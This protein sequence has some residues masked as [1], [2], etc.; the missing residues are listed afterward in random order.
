[1][2]SNPETDPVEYCDE[3]NGCQEVK[4]EFVIPRGDSSKAL[5]ALEEVL[6]PMPE[7][8][9]TTVEGNPPES[10]LPGRNL[11][12]SSS[13]HKM[14]PQRVAVVALFGDQ[15]LPR[16]WGDL[17]S[18]LEF[19]S[20]SWIH[21]QLQGSATAIHECGELGI[22]P[23]LGVPMACKHWPPAGFDASW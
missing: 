12:A 8:V 21:P 18:D 2:S 10:C 19:G 15:S 13:E 17:L 4:A 22:E 3:L 6:H 5:Y 20:L 9:P 16:G 7:S 1:M 23:A 14:L 11:G